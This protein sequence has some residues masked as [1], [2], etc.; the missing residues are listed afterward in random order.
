M[1]ESGAYIT[2]S[3]ISMSSSWLSCFVRSCTVYMPR[4]VRHPAI[5]LWVASCIDVGWFMKSLMYGAT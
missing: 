2:L 5:I 4:A 1:G 3:I